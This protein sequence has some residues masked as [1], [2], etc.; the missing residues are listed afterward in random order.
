MTYL[1]LQRNSH[2]KIEFTYILYLLMNDRIRSYSA[3]QN[4]SIPANFSNLKPLIGLDR[5]NLQ[6]GPIPELDVDMD[7][8]DLFH[9]AYQGEGLPAASPEPA[10]LF[11]LTAILAQQKINSKSPDV[12]QASNH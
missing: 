8:R 10:A 7:G 2:Y 1:I 5:Q 9:R 11:D 12:L 6:Q 4:D 3:H